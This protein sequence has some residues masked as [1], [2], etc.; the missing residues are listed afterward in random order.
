MPPMGLSSAPA[1]FQTLMNIIFQDY[2]DVFLVVYMDDLLIFSKPEKEHLHHIETVLSRL[3][4]EELY[5]SPKKCSF[6]MEETEFLGIIVG[7]AGIKVN[8]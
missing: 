8:P 1:T 7:L 3:K 6:M 5:V 4:S 2:I